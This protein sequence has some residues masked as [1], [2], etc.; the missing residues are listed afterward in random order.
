MSSKT[1]RSVRHCNRYVL[2]IHNKS[3]EQII[4]NSLIQLAE[5]GFTPIYSE[6]QLAILDGLISESLK[7]KSSRKILFA[8]SHSMTMQEMMYDVVEDRTLTATECSHAS[9]QRRRFLFTELRHDFWHAQNVVGPPELSNVIYK[10]LVH[11][12]ELYEKASTLMHRLMRFIT[13]FYMKIQMI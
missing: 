12:N 5:D 7:R 9:E 4:E 8:G 13:F 2:Q 10:N 11:I 6:D 1:L 3:K